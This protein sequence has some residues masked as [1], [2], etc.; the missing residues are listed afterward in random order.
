MN[1]RNI[2]LIMCFFSI[3][4][5]R[6]QNDEERRENLEFGVKA[7]FNISNVW[8]S[9]GQEFDADPKVG[10]AGGVFLGIPLGE[11]LG[12]QPELLLS[13]K[14]FQGEGTLF[15]SSYS[16]SRTTTYLDVPLQVQLKP[17]NYLTFVA[18]PQFSYLLHQNDKYSFGS[19]STEQEEEFE[20]DN[21][22]KNILG[23]V[24]GF[25]IILQS[26]VLSGRVGWDFQNN[27]GDG[28]SS[29]PRYKNRWAQM[30]VGIK[31]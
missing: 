27:H 5:L 10:F 6:A 21:I 7:G 3:A 14:G 17:T 24:G 18:G 1:K 13:Q 22:R 15:G 23:F 12:I 2:I 28:S 16:F 29:T 4:S 11:I 9:R 30:T 31:I 20:N 8:D 19:A 26:I 25:D